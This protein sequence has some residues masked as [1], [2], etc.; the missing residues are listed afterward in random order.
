MKTE[1]VTEL[2]SCVG[3]RSGPTKQQPAAS[4]NSH[5][6]TLTMAIIVTITTKF[7]SH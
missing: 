6:L 5:C 7:P 2:R 3:R 1:A 4:D